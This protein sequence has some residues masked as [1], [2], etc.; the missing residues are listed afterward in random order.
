MSDQG[1]AGEILFQDGVLTAWLE[2]RT[3]ETDRTVVYQGLNAH[4][5]LHGGSDGAAHCNVIVRDE[6]GRVMAGLLGITYWGWLA[7]N[8]MWV[9]E[10]VRGNGLGERMVRGAEAEAIR[11]GCHGV[12]IR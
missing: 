9:H 11:R 2:D 4:N 5:Q 12:Q 7:I 6:N 3:T 8:T 10:T 1:T